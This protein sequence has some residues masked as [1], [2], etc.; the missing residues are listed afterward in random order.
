M[1]DEKR[2]E[3][4]ERFGPYRRPTDLTIPKF[5]QIQEKALEMA[6]LIHLLCP[7]SKQKSK[8]LS[9]LED[10]KMNA[11]AAIAIHS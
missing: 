11:N 9:Y 10:V 8:A 2:N 5:Q 6:L 4:I 3:I 1:E 7:E